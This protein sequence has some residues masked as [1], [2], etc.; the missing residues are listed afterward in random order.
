MIL[1]WVLV[2]Q[3]ALLDIMLEGVLILMLKLVHTSSWC[4]MFSR[5]IGT[6]YAAP[7]P[8]IRREKVSAGIMLMRKV[9]LFNQVK[10]SK[11][12]TY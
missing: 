6:Y 7:N 2:G 4:E 3:L 5:S 12:L 10:A 8:A 11:G 9:S 1:S